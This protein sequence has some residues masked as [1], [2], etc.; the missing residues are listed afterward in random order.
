M[1]LSSK[2]NIWPP[3]AR[4]FGGASMMDGKT[5]GGDPVKQGPVYAYPGITKE[6]HGRSRHGFPINQDP[7]HITYNQSSV[8]TAKYYTI[9]ERTYLNVIRIREK[10]QT[11]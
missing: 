6:V 1:F 8:S 11:Y 5:H 4:L 9:T 10:L 2:L 7:S 3:S